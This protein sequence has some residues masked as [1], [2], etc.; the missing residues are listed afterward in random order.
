MSSWGVVLFLLSLT[1]NPVVSWRLGC[2]PKSPPLLQMSSVPPS[3]LG[4]SVPHVVVIGG[5]FG[6]WGAAKGLCENGCKVTLIDAAEPTGKEPVT[7]KSGKPFEAGH[8]G[9]WRDYPN[10]YA[11]INSYLK[12]D[13]NEIFTKWTNSSFY[14]PYGL[15]ATAPLWSELPWGELPSPLGQVLASAQLFTRLPI[16]DRGIT[17]ESFLRLSVHASTYTS[18]GPIFSHPRRIVVRDAGLQ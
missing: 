13:E 16:A 12:L 11:M 17:H 8:K 10:I 3:S 1:S 6:G 9:F 4:G 7:T 5:G 14:S 15:E 2:G 18:C